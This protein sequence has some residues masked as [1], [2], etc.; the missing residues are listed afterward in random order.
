VIGMM[1]PQGIWQRRIQQELKS[2]QGYPRVK[3]QNVREN[4]DSVEFDM[5]IKG[6]AIIDQKGTLGYEHTLHVILSRNYPYQMP[7]VEW[8]TPIWH[9]NVSLTGGVCIGALKTHNWNDKHDVKEVAVAIVNFLVSPDATDP[10]NRYAADWYKENPGALLRAKKEDQRIENE[11]MNAEIPKED[12]PRI[13]IQGT[14][15]P[16]EAHTPKPSD[17]PKITIKK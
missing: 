12:K 15:K 14:T 9:P 2:L 17:K 1:L 3:V 8:K 4:L 5:V 11:L 13:K 16:V 7:L 10:F 6:A